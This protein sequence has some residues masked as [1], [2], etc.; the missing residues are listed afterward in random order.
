[1]L[2]QQQQQKL[3]GTNEKETFMNNKEQGRKRAENRE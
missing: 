3:T 1:M 2:G